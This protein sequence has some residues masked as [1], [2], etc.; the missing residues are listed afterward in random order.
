[1]PTVILNYKDIDYNTR[2]KFSLFLFIILLILYGLIIG[3]VYMKN[4][5]LYLVAYEKEKK[6]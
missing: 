4:R 1:M 2:I 6:S 5:H 3:I